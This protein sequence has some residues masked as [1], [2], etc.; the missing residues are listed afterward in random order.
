[1]HTAVGTTLQQKGA[2][3]LTI[4]VHAVSATTREFCQDKFKR[5]YIFVEHSQ[6]F[7]VFITTKITCDIIKIKFTIVTSAKL[8]SS[9]T[10]REKKKFQ[11]FFFA[12]K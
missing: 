5:I 7:R 10:H 1:M 8:E 6:N 3:H 2:N 12:E 4:F 11:S 9:Q